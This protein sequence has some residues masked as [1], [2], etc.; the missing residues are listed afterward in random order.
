LLLLQ[1]VIVSDKKSTKLEDVSINPQVKLI[2]EK[3]K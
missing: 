1:Y 2:K 3:V